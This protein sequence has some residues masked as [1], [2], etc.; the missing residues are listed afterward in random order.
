MLQEKTYKSS[1]A[2]YRAIRQYEE[3]NGKSD[4]V[5]EKIEKGV[6]KISKGNQP[7]I[8]IEDFVKENPNISYEN[9]MVRYFS[10][11]IHGE[12]YY[13][14]KKGDRRRPNSHFLSVEEVYNDLN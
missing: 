4:F 8:S 14:L 7:K 9:M 5:M 3:K 11:G 6:F 2:A 13:E 12:G 10:D 1:S